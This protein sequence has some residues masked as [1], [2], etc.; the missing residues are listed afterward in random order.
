MKSTSTS[1]K[2]I[3]KATG[4]ATRRLEIIINNLQIEIEQLK[5]RITALGG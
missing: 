3:N 4:E 2:P 1:R 5:T